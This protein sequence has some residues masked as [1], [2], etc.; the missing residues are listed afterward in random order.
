MTRFLSQTWTSFKFHCFI[1]ELRLHLFERWPSQCHLVVTGHPSICK[2][3]L[4]IAKKT[5]LKGVMEEGIN[6][7]MLSCTFSSQLLQ[8]LGWCT[9]PCCTKLTCSYHIE[10]WSRFYFSLFD[11]AWS[12][13]QVTKVSQHSCWPDNDCRHG[14]VTHLALGL[15]A[16]HRELGCQRNTLF[17]RFF[18]K[19]WRSF[20]WNWIHNLEDWN[21]HT[22]H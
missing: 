9:L 11:E 15:E 17:K 10:H 20:A 7:T 22:F 16:L 13:G 18:C 12:H 3:M 14:I 21:R 6:T 4:S 19:F 5:F 1:V 8:H 2:S